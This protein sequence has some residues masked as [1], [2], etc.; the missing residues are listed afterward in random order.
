M[1][2]RQSGGTDS[3]P[4]AALLRMVGAPIGLV[5]G[6]PGHQHTGGVRA[7]GVPVYSVFI[8]L[9]DTQHD[10]YLMFLSE[11]PNKT[12]F[13][14][15]N[16]YLLAGSRVRRLAQPFSPSPPGLEPMGKPVARHLERRA[17]SCVMIGQSI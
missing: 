6:A 17:D 13:F 16:G 2:E 15:M 11:I 4:S 14:D 10:E 8:Q 5:I 7:E 12:V 3:K 9:Y 1:H